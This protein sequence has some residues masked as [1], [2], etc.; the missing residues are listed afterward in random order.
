MGSNNRLQYCC[1]TPAPT[2]GFG[3]ITNQPLFYNPASGYFHLSSNSPCINAGNNAYVSNYVD[4]YGNPRIANGTVDIGAY[5][6]QDSPSIISY[7]WLQQYHLTN[8]GSADFVD[9]DGDGLN[10]WQE[11]RTGTVPTN[12]LS[13]LKMLSVSNSAPGLTVT[14]QSASGVNYFLER[15]VNLGAPLPY[16]V[17]Q[18]NLVGQAG[19]TSFTDTT[20]TNGGPYFY[21]VGV[22]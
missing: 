18:S 20:A 16:T 22:Q 15:A 17:L 19:T 2:N 8:D 7:A 21:R 13:L 12:A 3:N 4:P 1:T 5:E 10:N 6:F 14:W 9:I 11:W